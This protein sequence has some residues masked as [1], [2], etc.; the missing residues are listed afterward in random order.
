MLYVDCEKNSTP[1]VLYPRPM[2]AIRLMGVCRT[3]HSTGMYIGT[4]MPA[5]MKLLYMSVTLLMAMLLIFLTANLHFWT[6][7]QSMRTGSESLQSYGIVGRNATGVRGSNSIL[8]SLTTTSSSPSPSPRQS[9]ANPFQG[10]ELA[11]IKNPLQGEELVRA[12]TSPSRRDIALNSSSSKFE[13]K[14]MGT[15]KSSA[16]LQM[17]TTDKRLTQE[18]AKLQ[19][20][21]HS[22][23]MIPSYYSGLL[24]CKIP[25]G[26]LCPT[27]QHYGLTSTSYSMHACIAK[28]Y[29]IWPSVMNYI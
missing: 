24:L 27:T 3:Y 10:E 11:K 16:L 19:T 18:F 29:Q 13:R 1:F 4:I 15:T 20:P 28:R 6:V 26:W 9:E 25:R 22:G 21:H 17:L 5:K 8:A 12:R 14:E 23:E 2:H 7:P